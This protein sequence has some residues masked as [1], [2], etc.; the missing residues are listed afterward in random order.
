MMAMAVHGCW[1]VGRSRLQLVCAQELRGNI[2][3]IAR[4][5]P[6]FPAEKEKGETECVSFP[7]SG[8]VTITN[9]KGR[10]IDF[11]YDYVAR[12]DCGQVRAPPFPRCLSLSLC[13]FLFRRCLL[14]A[15]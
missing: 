14:L 4:V 1:L 9:E 7:A 11:E 15:V 6:I 5:R 12:Q 8:E 2:R 13:C 10:S 3:V